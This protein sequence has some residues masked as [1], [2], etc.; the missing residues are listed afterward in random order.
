MQQLKVALAGGEHRKI[1]TRYI[2]SMIKAQET[3]LEG[4]VDERNAFRSE[5]L[6]RKSAIHVKRQTDL[7]SHAINWQENQEP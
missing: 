3:A 2:G 1:P 5:G 6:A 4:G 7:S